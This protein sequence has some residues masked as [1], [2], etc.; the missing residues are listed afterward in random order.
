MIDSPETLK[1]RLTWITLYQ[2]TQN[3]GLVCRRC[4]ISRPTLR[5]WWRRFSEQGE[6][7]L[8]SCSRRRKTLPERKL[9]FLQEQAVLD[10]RKKRRLGPKRLQSE[11]DRQHHIHLSTSTLWH[12]LKR[13]NVSATLRPR[14][15]LFTPKRYFLSTPG[16]RVQIDSCKIGTGLYQFTA[17]DD[18][19][20]LRVLGLYSNHQAASAIDFVSKR[21]CKELPFPIQRI[22]TDRGSEFMAE[23]FQ[24]LLQEQKIKFRPTPPR[25]PHLNGK[26]ERSQQTD[27][28]E[29]WGGADRAVPIFL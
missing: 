10:L 17:I 11:L 5:K 24:Q 15:R 7:G 23:A 12:A 1:A 29:F 3:A 28:I 25:S 19:T 26:V 14:R 8:R 16:E 6:E 21:V 9:S 22:Q 4:G 13:N 27:R 20:R 2:Q 18:C